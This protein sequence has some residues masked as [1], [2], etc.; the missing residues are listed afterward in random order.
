MAS[1]LMPVVG[2]VT[3]SARSPVCFRKAF[4]SDLMAVSTLTVAWDG[5]DSVTYCFLEIAVM[6]GNADDG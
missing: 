2:I 3:S 4:W 6:R 5:F 1:P